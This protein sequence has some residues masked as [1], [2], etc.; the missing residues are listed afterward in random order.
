MVGVDLLER[1]DDIQHAEHR[2]LCL[3]GMAAAVRAGRLVADHGGAAQHAPAQFVGEEA[4]PA[5]HRA[6]APRLL[7]EMAGQAGFGLLVDYLADFVPLRGVDHGAVLA[8]NPDP[9]DVQLGADVCDDPVD[10]GGLVLQHGEARALDD[11]LGQLGRVADGLLQQLLAAVAHD[12]DG[13]Q[14]H[15]QAERDHQVKTD[16]EAEAAPDH[17]RR[18]FRGRLRQQGPRRL[19]RVQNAVVQ[20]DAPERVAGQDQAGKSSQFL[21]YHRAAVRHGR[22]DI[23]EW[24]SDDGRC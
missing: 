20:A 17:A 1:V 13:E 21:V 11:H 10:V 16:L 5:Y 15:R 14:Q 8:Q 6:R 24:P 2:L 4:R 22:R 18:T 9:V 3:V 7:V 23:A 19:H 12:H